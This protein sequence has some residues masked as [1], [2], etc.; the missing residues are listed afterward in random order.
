MPDK[1]PPMKPIPRVTHDSWEFWSFAKQGQL[2]LRACRSCNSLFY[3][4]R[5]LCPRCM[6]DDLGWQRASGRGTVHAFTVVHRAPHEAFRPDVPYVVAIVELAEGVR[7]LS[8][9]TDCPADTV[10]IGM[11]VEAWFEVVSEDFSIPKFRPA[12]AM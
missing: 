5:M 7:L 3:Y 1:Q 11:Q 12:T 6:S 4:P 2:M 10:T 9:I 8:N